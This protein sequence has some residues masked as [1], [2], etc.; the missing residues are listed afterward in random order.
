MI[1][2]L[3]FVSALGAET[4]TPS[5]SSMNQAEW[6]SLVG[7]I[8]GSIVTSA[9]NENFLPDHLR[10]NVTRTD[11]IAVQTSRIRARVA[12][13]LSESLEDF[14]IICQQEHF[15]PEAFL[16]VEKELKQKGWDAHWIP[17]RRGGGSGECGEHSK[18]YLYVKLK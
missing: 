11:R 10:V 7:A 3:L 18:G 9:F 4:N 5:G 13:R 16:N 17:A 12:V 2:V 6:N 14:E 8:L 15:S 1:V